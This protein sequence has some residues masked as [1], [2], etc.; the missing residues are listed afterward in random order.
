VLLA[1]TTTTTLAAHSVPA[2]DSGTPLWLGVLGLALAAGALAV[3][4]TQALGERAERRRSR[5]NVTLSAYF[6]RLYRPTLSA[7]GYVRGFIV[8]INNTGS[9]DSELVQLAIQRDLGEEM[10]GCSAYSGFEDYVLEGPPIP[11]YRLRGHSS[12]MWVIDGRQWDYDDGVVYAQLGH[13]EFLYEPVRID[14]SGPPTALPTEP[15]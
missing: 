3:S 14:G 12:V 9:E 1:A 2:A 8:T 13:G 11:S 10:G 7:D 15:E 6:T 5:P 4:A